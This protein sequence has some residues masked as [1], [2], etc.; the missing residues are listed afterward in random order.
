MST[1]PLRSSC[2]CLSK[3][4]TLWVLFWAGVAPGMLQAKLT[5]GGCSWVTLTPALFSLR[6]FPL[7]L[8]QG[9]SPVCNLCSRMIAHLSDALILGSLSGFLMGLILVGGWAPCPLPFSLML[10]DMV[11][12]N[13]RL[14]RQMIWSISRGWRLYQYSTIVGKW[15][16]L[17]EK[18]IHQGLPWSYSS[19]HLL[20][21]LLVVAY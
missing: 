15:C 7:L 6:T 12:H 18:P 5:H 1:T 17:L 19:E 11:A 2:L 20:R 13:Y 16:C 4:S 10:H 9:V 3:G 14:L 21:F 8:F